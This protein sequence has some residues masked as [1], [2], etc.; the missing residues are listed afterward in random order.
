VILLSIKSDA[1]SPAHQRRSLQS[2][3]ARI[4]L[5]CIAM[6]FVNLT[7]PESTTLVQS[8]LLTTVGRKL[9]LESIQADLRP[10]YRCRIEI[11]LLADLG[12]SQARICEALG[13]SQETARYWIARA[14]SGQAHNWNDPPIGRPKTVHADYLERLKELVS[15]SPR[16]YGY[17]IQ[18]WTAQ[19]LSKHL[20]TELGI[21]LSS[22]HI[23][24]LLKQMGLSTKTKTRESQESN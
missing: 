9:L 5:I 15:N 17:A 2:L 24:R 23:N 20:A 13:C 18:C 1:L 21:Q 19:R 7:L 3:K 10:E 6:T 8:Q 11:M 4:Q 16:K 22:R 12:E 14:H